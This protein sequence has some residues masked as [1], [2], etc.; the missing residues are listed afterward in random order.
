MRLNPFL[1][2]LKETENT[3]RWDDKVEVEVERFRA[4]SGKKQRKRR[5]FKGNVLG[6]CLCSLY[7]CIAITFFLLLINTSIS[8]E[9]RF[10]L[11]HKVDFL[12]C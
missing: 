5:E 9:K 2:F 3:E 10:F 6:I 4:L 8:K 1:L 7:S 11:F 12:D